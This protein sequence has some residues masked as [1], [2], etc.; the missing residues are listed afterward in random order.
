MEPGRE[1]A[2]AAADGTLSA[3]GEPLSAAALREYNLNRVRC[4]EC[5][6]VFCC[7]CQSVPFHAGYES[8]DAFA[9]AESGRHCRW[10]ETKLSDKNIWAAAD[11]E[12]IEDTCT[13]E[14]CL[15]FAAASC[16]KKHE[17]CGHNCGGVR[18]EAT[19]LPCLKCAEL[20][21]DYCSI[22]YTDALGAMPV[23]KL[24]CG[25][26]VHEHCMKQK[27]AVRWG[28]SPKIGFAFLE[29]GECRATIEQPHL[30]ALLAPIMKL[31][32]KVHE[33]AIAQLNE[34]R[35]ACPATPRAYECSRGRRGE[36]R[37]PGQALAGSRSR[38][39][40]CTAAM[41]AIAGR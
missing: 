28:E 25:H 31:R 11:H 39:C 9:L 3:E 30:E 13:E 22:C 40:A 20:D 14:E 17:D 4:H 21:D 12:A 8:C 36:A 27:L 29:C 5:D 10:C 16:V 37:G 18:D 32:S 23:L 26:Y 7:A 33:M 6:T 34:E 2:T 19:C 41:I 38:R 15:A 24:G 1:D 35:C